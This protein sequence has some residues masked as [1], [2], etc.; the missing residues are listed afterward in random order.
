MADRENLGHRL[1]SISAGVD[2]VGLSLARWWEI[3]TTN[4]AYADSF[5]GAYI[6]F[7]RTYISAGL[8]NT[9]LATLLDRRR[10]ASDTSAFVDGG[11]IELAG[12]R[13]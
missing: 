3:A 2:R 5:A 6:L 1:F 11:G 12:W 9:A 7:D 10:S 8:D 4:G 13:E